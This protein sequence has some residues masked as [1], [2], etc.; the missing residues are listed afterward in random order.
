MSNT[1]LNLTELDRDILSLSLIDNSIHGRI[2]KLEHER[3]WNIIEDLYVS[4]DLINRLSKS[5]LGLICD[6]LFRYHNK[7]PFEER[8]CQMCLKIANYILSETRGVKYE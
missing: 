6:S 1:N 4:I 8:E 3:L 2:T 5:D 7:Y